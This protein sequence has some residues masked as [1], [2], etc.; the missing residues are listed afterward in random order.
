VDVRDRF[1]EDLLTDLTDHGHLTFATS[2]DSDESY[3][4]TVPQEAPR[5]R[6]IAP[7]RLLRGSATGHDTTCRF[8]TSGA[9]A[10]YV[11]SGEGT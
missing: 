6:Q 4:H 3:R 10:A 9:R 11:V 1:L 5:A 2:G 7:K 8:G